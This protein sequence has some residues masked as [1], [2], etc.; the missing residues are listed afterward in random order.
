MDVTIYHNPD[1]GTSRNTLA[2][3]EA[4]GLTPTVI[5]YLRAPP[6]RQRLVELLGEMNMR[7]R[8][9]IRE[10]G[11]PFKELGLDDPALTDDELV[12]AMLANPILI[13][14]PIVVTDKGA[15]LCRPSDLVLEL[16]PEGAVA[17]RKEEG[18]PLLRAVPIE[19][20]PELVA[21]LDAEMLPVQDVHDE[22]RHWFRF[23]RTDGETVGFGGFEPH[24]RDVLLRSIVVLPAHRGSGVGK[25]MMLLLMRKAFDAG[26][27]AG[28]ALSSSADGW[29]DR[30]GFKP[31]DR[32]EAPES[33]LG[34]RQARELCPSTASLRKRSLRP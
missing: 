18:V 10:K 27:R 26:G 22:G 25:N 29:L 14:R 4:A 6:S 16:L 28:Y 1:C 9:L 12:D 3:I 33:I 23:N 7:P 17:L 34:T 15:K 13:N 30:L 8:D 24:G 20:G 19:A 2:I 31:V 21:A 32:A 11:T 5:E